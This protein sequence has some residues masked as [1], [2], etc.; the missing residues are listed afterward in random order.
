VDAIPDEF[1]KY[2]EDQ[3]TLALG[4]ICEDENL[5]PKQFKSLVNAYIYSEQEPLRDDVF[6][7]LDSR[8]S[9]LEARKIGERI[10]T[11]M[12]EFVKVFVR[13]MAA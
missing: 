10:I 2:W 3:K 5:D 6:K 7:C 8:P 11:K 12:K 1:D 9:V 4:K 13:A